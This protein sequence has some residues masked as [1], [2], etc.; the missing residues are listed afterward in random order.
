MANLILSVCLSILGII[1]AIALFLA[2]GYLWWRHKRSQLQFIEPNDDEDS[3]NYS[4]SFRNPLLREIQDTSI[5]PAKGP[6]QQQA[7]TQ[8]LATPLQN[9]INRKLNGFLN[10]KTPLIG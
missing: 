2:G 4:L 3:S 6:P 1:I 10:L 5:P 8:S 7:T 9:N